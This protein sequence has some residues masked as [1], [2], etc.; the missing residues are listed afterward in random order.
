MNKYLCVTMYVLYLIAEILNMYC[1]IPGFS[2][3]DWY[4]QLENIQEHS[5]PNIEILKY[6]LEK[7]LIIVYNNQS[8]SII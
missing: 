5:L 7:F 1:I 8:S 4:L 6:T 3:L 2:Y